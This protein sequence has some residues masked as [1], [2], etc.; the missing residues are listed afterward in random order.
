MSLNDEDKSGNI[1]AVIIL[2]VVGKPREHLIETLEGLIKEMSEEKGVE[3]VN[4]TISDPTDLKDEKDF[5]TTFAE[6]E[7]KAEGI[8]QIIGLIFKYMPSHIEIVYPEKFALSSNLFNEVLNEIARRIHG[9]DE[10]ARVI[11]FERQILENK[12][13][14]LLDK[15]E[16]KK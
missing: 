13:K 9:Y 16:D 7:V 4:K 2:E 6:V 8:E 15:K 1:E 3:V 10:V 12:L 14:D 5:F 11:Q